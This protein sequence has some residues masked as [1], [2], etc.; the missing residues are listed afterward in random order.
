M[1][2][3]C[4]AWFAYDA[5]RRR[6]ITCRASEPF[7]NR[8]LLLLLLLLSLD[9]PLELRRRGTSASSITGVV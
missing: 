4:R 9:G 6:Y 7:I 2:A 8:P 3:L 5:V 1:T